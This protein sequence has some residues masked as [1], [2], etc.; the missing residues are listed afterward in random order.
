MD[1]YCYRCFC[2]SPICRFVFLSLF[3]WK[4]YHTGHAGTVYLQRVS[5][6]ST[7]GNRCHRPGLERLVLVWSARG[8][9]DWCVDSFLI[10]QFMER[11]ATPP[12]FY[13]TK[14]RGQNSGLTML[15]LSS[16]ALS[17]E[18]SRNLDFSDSAGTFSS[19]T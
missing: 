2:I 4:F 7:P 9:Y 14:L 5:W 19:M 16:W 11:V 18:N 8:R 10:C 13:G 6:W 12:P 3:L 17:H 1:G 15:L